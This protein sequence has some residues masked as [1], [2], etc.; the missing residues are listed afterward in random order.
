MVPGLSLPYQVRA[1]PARLNGIGV[2]IEYFPVCECAQLVDGIDVIALSRV[3]RPRWS[4]KFG[5]HPLVEY[6]L[7]E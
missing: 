1:T 7:H 3:A 2:A 4:L 5:R 6:S